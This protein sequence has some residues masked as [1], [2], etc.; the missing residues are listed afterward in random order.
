M[1]SRRVLLLLSHTLALVVGCAA[2]TVYSVPSQPPDIRLGAALFQAAEDPDTA[3]TVLH[4]K[5]SDISERMSTI[6]QLYVHAAAGEQA[7]THATRAIELC[8]QLSWTN[9]SPDFLRA[10]GGRQ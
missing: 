4:E 2:A 7:S 8:N 10:I 5:G 1:T 9:C 6:L 3:L